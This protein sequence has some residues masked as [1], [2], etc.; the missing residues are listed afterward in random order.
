MAELADAA[1]LGA[2][3]RKPLG[4]QIPLPAPYI[5]LPRSRGRTD[6]FRS[7]AIA[8]N[9]KE[10]RISMILQDRGDHYL[11]IR[12]TDHAVLAGF[13]ARLWGNDDFHKPAGFDSFCLAVSEHDNGWCE[14][15]MEPRLDLRARA[16]YT[17]MS[18]PTEEHIRN[19][20]RG[21]ERLSNVDHYA[22][23]LVNLHSSGLYDRA[24]ATMPGYSAKYVKSEESAMVEEH[25]QKLKL[26]QLR[27][28]VELRGNPETK[29][30]I[31]EKSLNES[32][33][34]LDV[35][36]RLSLYFCMGGGEDVLIDSVPMYRDEEFVDWEVRR[37]EDGGRIEVSVT[38]YPFGKSPLPISILAR[39]VPKRLYS[40][41][42]DLR[43][44][45]ATAPYFAM[46]FVVRD[47]NADGR[48][49]GAVA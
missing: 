34:L 43:R 35:L 3:G 28:K 17:F 47:A 19:Y 11:V 42:F 14:W 31:E 44:T 30:L 24:R 46:N 32:H 15:E 8:K 4:V 41:S 20:Q 9:F 21:V 10:R 7:H 26:Q 25:L 13:F 6:D 5:S 48:A 37:T 45:L 39:R 29:P 12:Q 2:A 49:Q 23:L 36:D 1:A 33:Q 18:V 22:A 16:P 27:L 40:D 38:P